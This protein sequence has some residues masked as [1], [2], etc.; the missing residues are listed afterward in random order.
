MGDSAARRG[1]DTRVCHGQ[2]R[3]WRK[4]DKGP[5]SHLRVEERTGVARRDPAA[6][7]PWQ[8]ALVGGED[9]GVEQARVA[10]VAV[11]GASQATRCRLH[12]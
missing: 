10:W 3:A 8:V 1:R 2:T 12:A 4:G 9:G 6:G 7:R 11:S 5:S